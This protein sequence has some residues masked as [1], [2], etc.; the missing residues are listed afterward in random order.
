MTGDDTSY[1]IL[2]TSIYI[3]LGRSAL[4]SIANKKKATDTA[5]VNTAFNLFEQ[6]VQKHQVRNL[7]FE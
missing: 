4:Q 7:M 5:A 3:S 2:Q 1:A 6:L